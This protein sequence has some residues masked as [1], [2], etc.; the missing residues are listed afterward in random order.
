MDPHSEVE[1]KFAADKV[2]VRDFHKFVA[3]YASAHL[4]SDKD[5]Q[6]YG[7]KRVDGVDTFYQLGDRVLRYRDDFNGRSELTYKSRKSKTSI[8][9]RIEINLP[10]K[11]GT[12]AETTKALL[13]S[14]GAREQFRITK[15]SHI[16][17][18]RAH[19]ADQDVYNATLAL[20]TV[21]KDGQAPRTFLEVEVE[22]TSVC[23]SEDALEVLGVWS[24][25]I[26]KHLGL[27]K[28]LNSS[29]YEIYNEQ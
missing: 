4:N 1:I 19:T 18:I 13:V 11:P 3:S 15:T 23:L 5:I 21:S 26:Q 14:L 6:V 12:P 16:Y 7:F 24:K 2:S 27:K 17:H 9:D 20:Y 8:I 28:P 10:I 25:R 29:L 22:A